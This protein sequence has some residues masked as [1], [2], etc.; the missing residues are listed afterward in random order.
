M[1]LPLAPSHRELLHRPASKNC[2]KYITGKRLPWEIYP[3]LVLQGTLEIST[4]QCLR[5][6]PASIDQTSSWLGSAFSQKL[7][8]CIKHTSLYQMPKLLLLKV[9]LQANMR[10][11]QC[12]IWHANTIYIVLLVDS[13]TEEDETQ[14]GSKILN[15]KVDVCCCF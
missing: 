9:S 10:V 7:T 4:A 1:T 8:T 14:I 13:Y 3:L 15:L 12:Y 11:L 5:F 6:S 2:S